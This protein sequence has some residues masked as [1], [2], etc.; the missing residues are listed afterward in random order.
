[1]VLFENQQFV[2]GHCF[3]NA[4]VPGNA[5]GLKPLVFWPH[6]QRP[7]ADLLFGRLKACPVTNPNCTTTGG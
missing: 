1:M 6:L 2:S 7:V 4:E 5:S 3:S